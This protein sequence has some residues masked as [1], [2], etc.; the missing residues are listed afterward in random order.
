MVSNATPFLKLSKYIPVAAPYRL[1]E[2][3]YRDALSVK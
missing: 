3:T 1:S 2:P